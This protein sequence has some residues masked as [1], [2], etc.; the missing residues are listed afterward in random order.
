[1]ITLELTPQIKAWLETEP[2]TRDLELGATLLLKVT[3]NRILHANIMRN[4]PAR[5]GIIEYHL[6]KIYS[7]RLQDI[8]HEQVKAMMT[9]V[10]AIATARGLANDTASPGA[11]RTAF[12]RGRRTDHDQLPSEIRQLYTDN[13][14][15]LRRMRD[16]H[17][18]IRLITPDNSTCPD[19]DRYPLAKYLIEQDTLYRENWNKYDHYVKG[20]PVAALTPAVDP[21]TQSRNAEKLCH[22]L[23]GK[24]A[25]NP[26]EALAQRILDT[27]AAIASPSVNLRAKMRSASLTTP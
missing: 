25:A 12:Q 26:S 14:E 16:T 4:L 13:A 3:R 11:T 7:R 22:L 21:R 2:A 6:K 5:A 1:M 10:D 24:Y 19:S 8:T 18:K 27:Y 20:T 17:T 15:I 9:Q 23:L